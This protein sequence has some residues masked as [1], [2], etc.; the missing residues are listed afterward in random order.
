[1]PTLTAY[2]T[3]TNGKLTL[4][5][6]KRFDEDIKGFKNS[7]VELTIKKKN[8]RSNNQNAYLWAVVYKEIQIRLL[9]LG[10]DVSPEWVHEFCR[11][12]FNAV[13]VI[14]QGGEEIGT[15]GG[16]TAEMNKEEFGIYIDKIIA[17]SASFLSIYI[18]QPN[19]A[20]TFQF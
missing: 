8:R 18:P 12:K 10:N 5:N 7:A 1:M 16:S 13:S 19:T 17:W 6:R 4:S 9:E 14:G 15:K 20:L 2:G 11:D 3:I